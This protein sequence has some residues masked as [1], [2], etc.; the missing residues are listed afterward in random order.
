MIRQGTIKLIHK[1]NAINQLKYHGA[2]SRNKIINMWRDMYGMRFEDC[3][4]QIRPDIVGNHQ[5]H[6][7][8]L[9]MHEML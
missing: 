3:Y 5:Y 2:A 6:A 9:L 4:I 8:K 1:G 7:K